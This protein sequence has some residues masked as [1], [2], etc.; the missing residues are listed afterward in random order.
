MRAYE[1]RRGG[2]M[3]AG[4]RI[5]VILSETYLGAWETAQ[6]AVADETHRADDD[7]EFSYELKPLGEVFGL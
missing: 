3:A 7:R 5:K 2:T 1:L 4:F 6:G